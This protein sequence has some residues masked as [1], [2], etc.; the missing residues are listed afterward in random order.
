MPPKTIK[1][2]VCATDVLKA[3]TLARAD[4]SRA[5]RSHEGIEAEADALR[6][7]DKARLDK[8]IDGSNK[9]SVPSYNLYNFDAEIEQRRKEVNEHCWLCECE[10][11]PVQQHMMD[12]M[13]ASK[14]LQLAGTFNFLTFPEDVKKLLGPRNVLVRM[15]LKQE[16]ID[17]AVMKYIKQSSL[18][19]VAEL[20]NLITICI[21]CGDK[22]GFKARIDDMMTPKVLPDLE[23]MYV[24]GAAID[25]LLNEM[26]EKKDKKN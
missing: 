2:S 7:R 5:C 6:A 25:P 8:A 12:V 20:L 21:T 1:C 9:P 15:P 4:G 18:R 26:A 13:V 22:H 14:R 3:Q 16:T 23:T 19:Q 10:G 17:R 11:V 24:M